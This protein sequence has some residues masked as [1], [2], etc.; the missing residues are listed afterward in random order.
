MQI[1]DLRAFLSR[2]ADGESYPGSKRPL[3]D[4]ASP[5][6]IVRQFQNQTGQTPDEHVIPDSVFEY[7]LGVADSTPPGI[8]AI[9]ENIHRIERTWDTYVSRYGLDAFSTYVPFH[10]DPDA[11]G[12]YISQR[13]IRYLG[14][15][16]YYWSKSH[17][18]SGQ[19]NDDHATFKRNFLIAG[20]ELLHQQSPFESKEAAFDLAYE[21]FRRYQW[22]HHQFELLAAYTEDASGE[23]SYTRYFDQCRGINEPHTDLPRVV[24]HQYVVRS[25]ACRNKTPGS[26]FSPLFS[27]TLRTFTPQTNTVNIADYSEFEKGC[28][29]LSR[30][31]R[32]G[33]KDSTNSPAL[34]LSRRLPFSTEIDGAI[35]RRIALY[36][37]RR[38]DHSDDDLQAS[39]SDTITNRPGV[40]SLSN[41][42]QY[43][44]SST[45]GYE[46]K[47]NKADWNV[48][49][50][51][52]NRIGKIRDSF[53][54]QNW[55]GVNN[56]Q[57]S[58]RYIKLSKSSAIR[59]VVSVD[60]DTKTVE[61]VDFG[62]RMK[63]PP[64]YGLHDSQ[65]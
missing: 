36:I 50:L 31:L 7:R 42:T 37:T 19:Q 40:H 9:D 14:H 21:I 48:K 56:G 4:G 18:S 13:G 38:E 26:L 39:E 55:Q 15:L 12:I 10:K 30:A 65:N 45:D 62:D 63:I 59:L 61:L 5:P 32:S 16:L 52:N 41:Q 20:P 34:E 3:A 24:A 54:T 27:R 58:Y 33:P 25:Q 46:R 29:E 44:I 60:E 51:L 35:P 8:I 6:D 23:E 64:K 22:F 47:Y 11:F 53:E 17:H 57:K 49:E 2:Y 28:L 43:A 1:N